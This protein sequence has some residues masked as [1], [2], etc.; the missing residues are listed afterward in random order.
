MT[1]KELRKRREA[2]G[3]SQEELARLAGVHRATVIRW[4][5]DQVDIRTLEAL[6]LAALLEK[7]KKK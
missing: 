5:M 4:E 3:L 6:G 1:G 2:A 7:R